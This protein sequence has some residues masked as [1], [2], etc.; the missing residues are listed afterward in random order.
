MFQLLKQSNILGF[1]N[2]L[3]DA[4]ESQKYGQSV[5]ATVAG[6]V[7]GKLEQL[8][9]GLYNLKDSRPRTLA[10]WLAK[11]TPFTGALGTDERAKLPIVGTD[12]FEEYLE[13]LLEAVGMAE[14]GYIT[15]GLIKIEKDNK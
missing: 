11:N 8:V 9:R 10:N 13:S 3:I 15:D 5:G 7:A 12:A 2:I 6:P 14:G 4:A 1:G